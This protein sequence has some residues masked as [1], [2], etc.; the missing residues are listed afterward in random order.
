MRVVR[1]R[2]AAFAGEFGRVLSRGTLIK[3]ALLGELRALAVDLLPAVVFNLLQAAR[4]IRDAKA[5]P[6]TPPVASTGCR[7]CIM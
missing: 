2:F 7:C 4:A 3:P 5:A 1:L 6:Q